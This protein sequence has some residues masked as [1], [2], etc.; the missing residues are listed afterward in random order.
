MAM[1]Q[2]VQIGV[3][4]WTLSGTVAGSAPA[5]TRSNMTI[6]RAAGAAALSL[7]QAPF[8]EVW[9]IHDIY[10]VGTNPTPDCQLIPRVDG[11][12]QP[13]TPFVSSINIANLT[14]FTL[15]LTIPIPRGSVVSF[16]MMNYAANS[17]TTAVSVTVRCKVIRRVVAAQPTS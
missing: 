5:N 12:D 2:L 11:V 9:H 13:V 7:Q 3:E 8:R 4:E 6:Q 15:P 10:Y 1:A 14:R 17:A 16:D